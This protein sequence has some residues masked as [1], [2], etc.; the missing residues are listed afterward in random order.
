MNFWRNIVRNSLLHFYGEIC[1]THM[2]YTIEK[3]YHLFTFQLCRR[4]VIVLSKTG[5]HIE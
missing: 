5:I 2:I 1:I 4:S 3:Y